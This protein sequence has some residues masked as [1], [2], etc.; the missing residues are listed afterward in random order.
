MKRLDK[1]KQ[2]HISEAANILGV[3]TKTVRNWEKQ[4]KIR[5]YRT[6]GG[7]RRLYIDD[8]LTLKNQNVSLKNEI[9]LVYARV[10]TR[11]QKDN[12]DRQ[13]KRLSDYCT[14]NHYKTEVYKDIASGLNCSRKQFIKLLQRLT[15]E[16]V[17]RVVVEYKD[18]LVRVCFEIFE[19]Y[20]NNLGVEVIVISEDTPKC[21]EQELTEDIISLVTVYS[22]RFNGRKGG[23]KKSNG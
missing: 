5:T 18:R 12:L 7:H 3:T 13:V 8:I 20:C 15:D 14:K 10:S 17:T 9:T 2:L 19:Q 4:G 11:E 21:F 6:I 23:K 22:A 1:S 16:E